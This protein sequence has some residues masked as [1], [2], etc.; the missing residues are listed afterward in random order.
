MSSSS[1]KEGIEDPDVA[2]HKAIEV[3][4]RE[5][6]DNENRRKNLQYDNE[7]K[8][9]KIKS[10]KSVDT[11]NVRDGYA[12][13]FICVSPG[14][15]RSEDGNLFD[16]QEEADSF[17][18]TRLESKELW[19]LDDQVYYYSTYERALEERKKV[20]TYIKD[21]HLACVLRKVQFQESLALTIKWDIPNKYD[22]S[23]WAD[24][25][26]CLKIVK[27]PLT[28]T[29]MR[30]LKVR[31]R[32]PPDAKVLYRVNILHERNAYNL[33]RHAATELSKLTD[34]FPMVET[35]ENKRGLC[36]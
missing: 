7:Q 15:D 10:I 21:M 29:N 34:T 1:N 32:C 11:T 9:L 20:H 8:R 27:C 30:E 25:A 33:F 3:L 26:Y 12:L 23:R 17:S 31:K 22:L 16:T 13:H 28:D 14:T 36:W 5:I 18:Y 35:F 24:I 2:K 4:E 6:E 19:S